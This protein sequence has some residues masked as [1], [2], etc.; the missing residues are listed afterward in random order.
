MEKWVFNEVYYIFH[1][2]D[3]A[4]KNRPENECFLNILLIFF[5]VN[6]FFPDVKTIT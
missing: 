5:I 4:E 1:R 3:Q 6:H 2:P